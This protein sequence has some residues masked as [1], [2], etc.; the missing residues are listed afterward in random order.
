MGDATTRGLVVLS[1]MGKR[2]EQT[3]SSQPVSSTLP[4]YLLQYLPRGWFLLPRVPVL[5]SLDDRLEP[6]SQTNS[7]LGC[8]TTA[9]ESK[10]GSQG[11]M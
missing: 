8:F 5:A 10:L 7:F 3:M 11:V 6:E 2:A 9:M 4:W 1:C